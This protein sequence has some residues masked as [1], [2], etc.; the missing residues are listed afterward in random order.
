MII[1]SLTPMAVPYALA[2]PLADDIADAVL[3]AYVLFRLAGPAHG[4]RE[5]RDELSLCSGQGS[6]AAT[7][8]A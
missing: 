7:L 6:V 2:L 5:A 3:L 1:S 4:V 8:A